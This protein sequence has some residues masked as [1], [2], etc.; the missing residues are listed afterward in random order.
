M[1]IKREGRKNED[2]NLGRT[3]GKKIRFHLKSLHAG[4]DTAVTKAG[5]DFL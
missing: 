3:S 5:K 2:I 1:N 4:E